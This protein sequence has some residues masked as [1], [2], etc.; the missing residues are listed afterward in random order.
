MFE[1]KCKRTRSNSTAPVVT[2]R[3]SLPALAPRHGSLAM[4]PCLATFAPIVALG[5][6]L[7]PLARGCSCPSLL[8]PGP[9]PLLPRRT[10][11]PPVA[12]LPLS[13]PPLVE[14]RR[15]SAPRARSSPSPVALARRPGSSPSLIVLAS[16]PLVVL[17]LRPHLSPSFLA[18]RSCPPPSS[19]A[20]RPR[21]SPAATRSLAAVARWLLAH[22]PYIA[23]AP[24]SS[25]PSLV[26]LP[27]L[28]L[29]RPAFARAALVLCSPP[30]PL[31][32]GSSRSLLAYR[33]GSA[34]C[35][36]AVLFLLPRGA[37]SRL[38]LR[39]RPHCSSSSLF[40]FVFFLFLLL[41]ICLIML[42]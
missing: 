16:D 42:I 14:R 38:A 19:L 26:A 8:A 30:W 20:P 36:L 18:P 39:P 28:A 7:L 41:L 34:L 35:A 2:G 6:R 24:P 22:P 31:T 15:P 25:S 23:L 3:S 4:A 13:P 10:S 1:V 9:S 21:P 37:A 40:F 12:L 29:A 11:R 33:L 32:L 17:A 5:R 27:P